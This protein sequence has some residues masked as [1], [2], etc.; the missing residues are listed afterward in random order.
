MGEVQGEEERE[1]GLRVAASS[2]H[3][4]PSHLEGTGR[5]KGRACQ[6]WQITTPAAH[7]KL[8]TS[9]AEPWMRPLSP[10]PERPLFFV[11]LVNLLPDLLCPLDT[12]RDYS[13]RRRITFGSVERI[14]RC[15]YV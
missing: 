10:S 4:A 12:R 8:L 14:I 3:R 13:L 11:P 9:L 1:L 6:I 5:K 7:V 2:F 15:A